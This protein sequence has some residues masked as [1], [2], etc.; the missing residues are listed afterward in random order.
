MIRPHKS[1][2]GVLRAERRHSRNLPTSKAISSRPPPINPDTG[3]AVTGSSHHRTKI[4]SAPTWPPLGVMQLTGQWKSGDSLTINT[5]FRTYLSTA[6][7]CLNGTGSEIHFLNEILSQR[8]AFE[9]GALHLVFCETF[10][11]ISIFRLGTGNERIFHV[12]SPLGLCSLCAGLAGLLLPSSERVRP[13]ATAPHHDR[14]RTAPPRRSQPRP[15]STISARWRSRPAPRARPF[16]RRSATSVRPSSPSKA[17]PSCRRRPIPPPIS[18]AA[19]Y[20][21]AASAARR[22]SRPR[23]NSVGISTQGGAVDQYGDHQL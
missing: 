1:I 21:P 18:R 16:P 11:C 10:F 19:A 22:T 12:S 4:V 2:S 20:G 9:S 3:R 14:S 6:E 15:R 7:C 17:A 13:G 8:A 23:S 5:A